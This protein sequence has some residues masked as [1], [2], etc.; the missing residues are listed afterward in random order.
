MNDPQP[1]PQLPA[2]LAALK[3]AR[4]AY[5]RTTGILEATI[6]ATNYSDSMDAWNAGHQLVLSLKEAHNALYKHL[7]ELKPRTP[8][9]DK[10]KPG[11]KIDNAP[12]RKDRRAKKDEAVTEANSDEP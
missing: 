12:E 7:V 10:M 5:A 4:D 3:E 9:A 6:G 8:K 11:G 1:K 2:A